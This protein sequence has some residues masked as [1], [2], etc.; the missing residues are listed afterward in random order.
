M[1]HFK[2]KVAVVTGAANGIGRAIVDV[3]AREGMRV[4]LAD[5]NKEALAR[6]E[7]ELREG[8]ATVLAVQTDVSKAE[9]IEEL[10]R[11]AHD[12]FGGVHLLFNNA[13]V[14]TTGTVWENTLSDWRWVLGVN[15][16]GVIHGVRTFVPMMLQ[17]DAEGHIVNTASMRGLSRASQNGVY[18]VSKHGVVALTE[19]L[20]YELAQREAKIKVSVL[21]PGAID[22]RF[23]DVA[24]NRL[25]ENE[26]VP[27]ERS[28]TP[29]DEEMLR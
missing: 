16:W 18:C 13:G 8:G 4:V 14:M 21:C 22:T 25:I 15:L 17:Q 27:G 11:R 3:C 12:A 28:M 2:D 6:A 10:A 26:N 23:A 24:E 5:I 29:E 7:A 20:H 1:R 9:D 19:T